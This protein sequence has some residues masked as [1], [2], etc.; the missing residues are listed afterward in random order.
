MPEEDQTPGFEHP[1]VEHLRSQMKRPSIFARFGAG[2]KRLVR[3]RTF[4]TAILGLLI[5]G[6]LAL[7]YVALINGSCPTPLASRVSG[8]PRRLQ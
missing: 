6:V 8:V 5:I 2:L 3:N 7:G 1:D 4:W